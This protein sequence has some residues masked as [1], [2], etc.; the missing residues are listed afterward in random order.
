M[1]ATQSS[2]KLGPNRGC[3]KGENHD[4][5]YDDVKTEI[6]ACAHTNCRS[7]EEEARIILREAVDSFQG[8]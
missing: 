8:A 5:T 1:I 3:D 4:P 6:R 2:V 7:M